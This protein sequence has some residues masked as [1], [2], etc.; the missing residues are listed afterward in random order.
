MCRRKWFWSD[1]SCSRQ[2]LEL[3]RE[4]LK[5]A[6][7]VSQGAPASIR[8]FTLLAPENNRF[9]DVLGLTKSSKFGK[10][11]QTELWSM[12]NAIVVAWDGDVLIWGRMNGTEQCSFRLCAE[13]W[14][15]GSW[16]LLALKNA[17]QVLQELHT[18]QTSPVTANLCK[19]KSAAVLRRHH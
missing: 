5:E 18:P 7:L 11:C 1:F 4:L 10:Q 3:L 9:S 19:Q 12:G 2:K 15:C 17:H 8:P 13:S 16:S 14:E 6:F